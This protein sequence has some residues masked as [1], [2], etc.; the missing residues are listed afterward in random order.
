MRSGSVAEPE[1]PPLESSASVVRG[2]RPRYKAGVFRRGAR[3][4][5]RRFFAWG[6]AAV[7]AFAFGAASAQTGSLTV[8]VV[9]AAGRNPVPGATVELKNDRGLVAPAALV[10]GPDGKALFPVL[11]IGA[12]YRV[13]VSMPGFARVVVGD[14]TV[15]S[16]ERMVPVA[17]L[18]ER[19]EHETVSAERSVVDLAETSTI[20]KF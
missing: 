2:A 8:A 9:D 19:V 7:A 16:G 12:G 6:C 4:G 11:P 18:E 1:R 13:T 3:V 10:T 20:T 17:L 15:G 5:L 14:L